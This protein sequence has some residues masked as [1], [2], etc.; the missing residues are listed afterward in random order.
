MGF[1]YVAQLIAISVAV[2]A[3]S[4]NAVAVNPL[5]APISI[6]WG[7]SGPRAFNG[8]N[9]ELKGS[10]NTIVSDAWDRA[11]EAI[12][13]H[14]TSQA[15]EAPAGTFAPFPTA[16]ARK[17]GSTTL[18][19]VTVQ[20]ADT[21][22]LLQHGVDETYTL[23]ITD[24]SQTVNIKAETIWGVLHAFTTL[25]QIV[26]SDGNGG[27]MVEQPVSIKDGPLYLYRGIMIDSGRNFI[28]LK[29]I[30]EQIDGMALS[31]L[32]V[33]HW[34]LVDSQSWAVQLTSMPSMTLDAYSQREI[35][36][37]NDIKDVIKYATARGVRVIPEID[38]PGHSA[39]GWKQ[40]DPAIVACADSWWSNDNW[41]SHTA[42][43]PNPG[44]LEILNPNTY[45]AVAKVYTELSS[46]FS[47]NFFHVGGDEVQKGCYN[48][49]IT[50]T[51][52]FA[53]NKSRTYDDLLQHWV[54]N[55]LPI[56]KAPAIKN[57]RLVM[58][59]DVAIG[60]PKAHTK[61]T[62]TG[63]DVIVS[64]SDW[65]YLDCGNGGWV[66]NDPRYSVQ[67]NPD[68]GTGTPNFNYGGGGGSWCAPYKTWQRIYDYDFTANLTTAEAKHVIGVTAPLWAEQVDDQVISQ[69]FWPRAAALG[70]LAWSGN[71]NS[72]GQK[73][74]TELT[75]RILNFREYLVT[76]GVGAA[77]L[78]PKYCLQHPHACDLFLDQT[79]L[80][81]I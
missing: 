46:M 67:S 78:M 33:L 18:N 39:S 81:N 51:E 15:T 64:S 60:S 34:H 53:A 73:R 49:S 10:T 47:D 5:P 2:S 27:L 59:E 58:W 66:G 4:S 14:W 75:A 23:D 71:K 77:P 9:L 1:N 32:N 3:G 31:K 28:S 63:Y 79:A 13:L 6:T 62:S 70:E 68:V 65:F 43:E 21:N 57:R 54:D 56:F 12:G 80:Y 45:K 25:Q 20:I 16:T 44:Q 48:L 55:A 76:L 36:S 22:A 41:P 38:M 50:T 7:T 72:K 74:T 11:Y 8:R 61:L 35:Y 40:I 37:K 17:R 29:K 42:V 69:K 52:W 30:F 26:I 19:S 24:S